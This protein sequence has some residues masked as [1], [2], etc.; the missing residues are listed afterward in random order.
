MNRNYLIIAAVVVVI[1][2]GFSAMRSGDEGAGNE[3]TAPAA[4][5]D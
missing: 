5:T 4:V 1:V 3:E 2:V